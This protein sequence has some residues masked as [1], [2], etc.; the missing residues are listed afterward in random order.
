MDAL[1]EAVRFLDPEDRLNEIPKAKPEELFLDQSIF[2][3]HF[4]FGGSTICPW[5]LFLDGWDEVSV[6]AERDFAIRVGEILTQ[7]RDKFLNRGNRPLVRVILTGRP[8]DAVAG[9]T[10]M[11][12]ETRLLTIRPLA[13]NALR[14][15]INHLAGYLVDPEGTNK[16]E[17]ER[18]EPVLKDY[19]EGYN[20]LLKKEATTR[21]PQHE[22]ENTPMQVLGLPLL[23]HLA[24]RL[25]VRWPDADLQPL[26]S[27]P[28]T[29]YRYLT[30]LTCVKG[31]RYGKDVYEPTLPSN[32]LR[33]LLHE[34][35]A[36]MTVFGR[37]HIPYDELDWRLSALDEELIERVNEMT[38]D[39]PVINLMISFF[40]KGGRKELGAE[41]LHKSFREYLFAE[42]VVEALKTYGRKVRGNLAER[43]PYWKDFEPEDPRFDLSRRLGRLLAPQWIS[44]EVAAY[45]HALIEWELGRS[46]G[47]TNEV[48]VGIPT[49]ALQLDEWVRVR[50]ALADLWNWWGEG[51]H[52]RQ[53]PKF[54]G[55]KLDDWEKPYVADLKW[56]MPKAPE[57][58]EIPVARRSTS[59][60]AHLGDGLCR[61]AALVHHYVAVPPGSLPEWESE[62]EGQQRQHTVTRLYQS[63][64]R[65]GGVEKIRFRPSGPDPRYFMNYAARIN[66]AGWHP[67]YY[68]P[69]ELFLGSADFNRTSL[70]CA[71]LAKSSFFGASFEGANLFMAAMFSADLRH[72][73]CRRARFQKTD[74]TGASLEKADVTQAVFEDAAL[75]DARFYGT[76]GI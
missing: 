33:R 23:A 50:D 24:V 3:H 18:F 26:V 30:D 49:S 40:F 61:L 22:V 53:Q 70:E 75:R 74:L 48:S 19:E 12:K 54:Q 42:C 36:A 32:D 44:R 47:R 45:L 9:S 10:F 43:V 62:T 2:D 57:R 1:P 73:N 65:L 68:F 4:E 28:T 46:H 8:S 31:G 69:S 63:T 11:T 27:N 20:K 66:S 15:F 14:G 58:G 35:A 64:G 41:F 52:L 51:V 39:H 67:G 25:M 59:M 13:P 55:K 21:I 37:D 38:K 17:P 34:T 29:L 7:I 60:D 76:E 6:A 71:P 56:S 72:S 5:V 16:T